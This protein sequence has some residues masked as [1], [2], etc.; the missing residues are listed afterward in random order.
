MRDAIV[1]F[2]DLNLSDWCCK[3]LTSL[4][5]YSGP[6]SGLGLTNHELFIEK[7]IFYETPEYNF[8]AEIYSWNSLFFK[9]VF[10]EELF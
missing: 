1:I 7:S 3:S 6:T 9:I 8:K 10:M 2:R 5:Q 4:Q